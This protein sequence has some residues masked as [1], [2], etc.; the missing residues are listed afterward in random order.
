MYLDFIVYALIHIL[1]QLLV[2]FAALWSSHHC[3]S[4]LAICLRLM[5][6]NKTMMMI[7]Q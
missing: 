7:S 4:V 1:G 3:N 5:L 2:Q 6:A